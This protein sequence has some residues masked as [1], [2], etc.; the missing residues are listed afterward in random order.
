MRARDFLLLLVMGRALLGAEESPLDFSDPARFL[1]PGPQSELVE[2]GPVLRA[3]GSPG[4]TLSGI[5]RVVEWKKSWRNEP[6]GGRWVGTRTVRSLIESRL[7]TGCHD[8][9]L[10]LAAVLRAIGIPALMVDCAGLEWARDFPDRRRDFAGHVFV[11][12]WVEKRWILLDS[13]SDRY[14][15]PFDPRSDRFRF[16]VGDQERFAVLFRGIDPASY[17]VT[18]LLAL[19]RAMERLSDGLRGGP[20]P[21]MPARLGPLHLP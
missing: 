21:A 12:A 10:L 8:H 16:P 5:R 15:D 20:E 2:A 19:N 7:L 14:L 11:L 9:A 4:A 3:C 6:A 18:N 17:G 1:L 13:T